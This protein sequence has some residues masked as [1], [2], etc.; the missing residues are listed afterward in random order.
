M[1]ARANA[2]SSSRSVAR[3]SASRPAVSPTLVLTSQLADLAHQLLARRGQMQRMQ[4]PV[5]GI[6][7]TFDVARGP[8]AR[9][10]RPRPGSATGPAGSLSACWLAPGLG[11][12]R[13]Q[14]ARRAAASD[15]PAAICVGELSG[16]VMTELGEQ[17]NATV[18]A[19][20]VRGCS[21]AEDHTS[22]E[23]FPIRTIRITLSVTHNQAYRSSHE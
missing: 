13:A 17:K 7:A 20:A 3:C 6:A 2:A 14:D 18:A 1:R 21:H 15:R 22:C 23:R 8:P 9:R 16:G 10:H 4:S 5:V 19:I 11:R 12:D